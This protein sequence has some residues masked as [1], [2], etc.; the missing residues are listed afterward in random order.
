MANVQP[1]TTTTPL[2]QQES[3]NEVNSFLD[4]YYVS[5]SEA[6]WRIFS[7][8]L[9]KEYP[10]HQRLAIHLKDYQQVFFSGTDNPAATISFQDLQTVEGQLYETNQAAC[11]A[12]GLLMDDNK[13]E[14]CMEE[15]ASYQ[16]SSS[17]RL[18]CSGFTLPPVPAAS[19]RT[20]RRHGLQTLMHEQEDLCHEAALLPDPAT[21]SFN[22][23]QQLACHS[24]KEVLNVT[25]FTS[26]LFFIDGLGETKKTF[27]FNALLCHVCRQGKI[28]LAVATSG[29]A[30]L[31]LVGERTAHSCKLSNS[32]ST[33]TA[34][35]IIWDE[36]SMISKDICNA[37]N[38][39]MQDIM[40]SRYVN[41]L[42]L[43]INM[44]ISQA[45]MPE[46]ETELR[47]FAAFLLSVGSDTILS[48]VFGH[49][50]LYVA[51]SRVRKLSGIKIM[52][53]ISDASTTQ[54]TVYT[55][56]TVYYKVF[57]EPTD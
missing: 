27:V 34:E 52:M 44:Q 49:C 18:S 17:L 42:N 5:A 38:H 53:D 3:V 29:I 48:S 43:T 4:A 15:A 31:L 30:A 22:I 19:N 2:N 9:H 20:R 8:K 14:V 26:R 13:W 23:D 7:F 36:A 1:I 51:L 57:D 41:H 6:C 35:L 45:T 55:D 50:Q 25:T 10:T 56:N 33:E 39:S 11:H 16:L 46:E 54:N 12:L 24:I 47:D 37:V 40:K 28:A 32:Q 21:L